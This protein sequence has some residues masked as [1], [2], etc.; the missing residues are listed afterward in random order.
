MK[1]GSEREN[2]GKQGRKERKKGGGR[3]IRKEARERQRDRTE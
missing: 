2:K 3:R 1:G